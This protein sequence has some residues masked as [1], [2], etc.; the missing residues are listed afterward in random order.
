VAS[1]LEDCDRIKYVKKYG[2]LSWYRQTEGQPMIEVRGFEGFD[3]P[4]PFKKIAYKPPVPS[5]MEA[6]QALYD[7]NEISKND[8]LYISSRL[9][10]M[11]LEKEEVK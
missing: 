7:M 5:F 11:A 6:A 3:K 1:L 10:K 2:V 4:K 8:L 9:K